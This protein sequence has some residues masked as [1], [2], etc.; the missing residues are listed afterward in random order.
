MVWLSSAHLTNVAVL[1]SKRLDACAGGQ[2]VV[3]HPSGEPGL[4]M[5]VK[6]LLISNADSPS[7]GGGKCFNLFQNRL[8]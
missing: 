4:Q 8:K 6:I 1:L 5:P 7:C 3:E 2:E